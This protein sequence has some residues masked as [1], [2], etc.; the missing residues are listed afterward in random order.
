MMG[1]TGRLRMAEIPVLAALL[2]FLP[3][4]VGFLVYFAVLHAPRHFAATLAHIRAQGMN[5]GPVRMEVAIWSLAAYAMFGLCL[6]LTDGLAEPNVQR[7]LFIGLAAL[8][9]P[10][11]LLVDGKNTLRWTKNRLERNRKQL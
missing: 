6:W 10:H 4:L 7:T 3:P 1:K 11:M 2:F 8:T 5:L 9:A